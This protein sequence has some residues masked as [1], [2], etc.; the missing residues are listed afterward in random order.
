[1]NL[2]ALEAPIDPSLLQEVQ[3]ELAPVLNVSWPSGN[4]KE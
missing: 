2:K 4:W 1:M 3:A